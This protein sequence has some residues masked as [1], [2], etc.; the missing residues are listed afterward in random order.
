LWD[1]YSHSKIIFRR[2]FGTAAGGISQMQPSDAE[3][4]QRSEPKTPK[5]KL[6]RKRKVAKKRVAPSMVL[7]ARQPQF[8]FF[9]NGIW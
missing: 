2:L 5:P 4:L 3:H 7:V 6:L 1:N 8:G 9:G